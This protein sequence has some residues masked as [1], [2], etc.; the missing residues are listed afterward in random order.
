M[1]LND[2]EKLT[3]SGVEEPA[4]QPNKKDT[5]TRRIYRWCKGAS[6]ADSVPSKA[7][8]TAPTPQSESISVKLEP[9]FKIVGII[10]GVYMIVG[11]FFIYISRHHFNGKST[12]GLVDSIYYIASTVT[13]IGNMDLVPDTS[14]TKLLS[15]IFAFVGMGLVGLVMGKTGEFLAAK[16]ERIL[17]NAI[18]LHKKLGPNEFEEEV[19]TNLVMKKIFMISIVASGL[20]FVG[21][22]HLTVVERFDFIDAFYWVCITIT[23]CG[24]PDESFKHTKGRLFAVFWMLSSTMSLAQF[25]LKVIELKFDCRQKTLVKLVLA[26]MTK[27]HDLEA[28]DLVGDGA[29]EANEYIIYK[30]KEMG[31]IT[32]EDISLAMKEFEKLDQSGSLSASDT[33]PAQPSQTEK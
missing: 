19:E 26:Q 15:S 31:K 18:H 20:V 33:K 3:L 6:F 17:M 16:Q 23:T 22:I 13:T 25:F 1:A 2:A 5:L 10:F 7:N 32:Q 21:T 14:S 24:Y 9:N 29:V 30:L 11:T 8:G 27:N 28:A 4:P 12:N